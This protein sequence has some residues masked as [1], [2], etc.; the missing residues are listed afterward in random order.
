MNKIKINST[1]LREL[2]ASIILASLTWSLMMIFGDEIIQSF[3]RLAFGLLPVV[4]VAMFG[5]AL[6]RHLKRTGNPAQKNMP[7]HVGIATALTVIFVTQLNK[8]EG[9]GFAQIS[10][11]AAYTCFVMVLCF[12]IGARRL[13]S[14]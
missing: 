5:T 6:I 12:S 4:P 8:L 2:N 9:A 13:L 10:A 11:M 1:S 14:K 7:S 3:G